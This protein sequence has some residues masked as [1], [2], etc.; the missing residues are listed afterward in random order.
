MEID[1]SECLVRFLP[2]HLS[3]EAN[4]W[5][6]ANRSPSDH[7]IAENLVGASTSGV[8]EPMMSAT[9]KL[10]ALLSFLAQS[11]K[12]TVVYIRL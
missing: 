4:A 1:A 6:I 7:E 5:Y 10:A 11:T 12:R 2:N 8:S 3:C 9:C